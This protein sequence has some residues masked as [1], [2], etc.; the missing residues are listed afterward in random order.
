[1]REV[2]LD[3]ETTGLNYNKGD[4]IIEVACVELINHVMTEKKIQFYCSTTKKITEEA[5]NIHG[6]TNKFLDKFPKFIEQIKG[7]LSFIKND[8]LI[9]HNAEF[10]LGFINN[11]LKLSGYDLLKNKTIDTVL[12]S[13]KVLN[14]RIANLDYLCR[15][16][17]I[18]LSKRNQH[19][20]LL[21]CQLLAKVYLELLGGQQTSLNLNKQDENKKQQ[22][23]TQNIRSRNI[24]QIQI[25]QEEK[26]LHKE[27]VNKIKNPLWQKINY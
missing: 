4:R 16:F 15:R 10:D 8:T 18:D 9:I 13:R 7:F 14:T 19:G 3:I 5:S 23:K 25:T 27:L 12:L 11:E 22:T 20:A 21:D 1:M 2:V 17:S 24:H 26:N 6:L